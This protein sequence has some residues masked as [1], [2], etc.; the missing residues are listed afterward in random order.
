LTSTRSVITVHSVDVVPSVIHLEDADVMAVEDV[1]TITTVD[2]TSA[3]L[4]TARAEKNTVTTTSTSTEKR[5]NTSMA[6]DHHLLTDLDPVVAQPTVMVL[7]ATTA[8]EALT[9]TITAAAEAG[10]HGEAEVAAVA[11]AVEIDATVKAQVV[12]L[13]HSTANLSM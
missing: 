9:L 6:H 5:T 10:A 8:L 1:M 13:L 7:M 2:L 4:K 11:A 12:P 3:T